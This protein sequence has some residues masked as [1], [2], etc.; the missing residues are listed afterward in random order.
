MFLKAKVLELEARKPIVVLNKK[1]SEELDVKPL[2]RLSLAYK[3]KKAVAIV[4]VTEKMVKPGYIGLYGL[5]KK[6]LKAKEDENIN[7]SPTP[8]PKSLIHIRQK[9]DGRM[10]KP[11]EIRQVI[12]DVVKDKLSEIEITAFIT[13]LHNHGM[14][15]EET[16]A[17]STSMARTGKILLLGKDRKK[18]FDKH[19]IGGVCGDKTSMLLVPIIAAAG[20]TI[21]KTSSRAITSPAGTADRFECLAPV[22]LDMDEIKKTV[23]KTNGCLVWGGGVELAPADDMFIHVEYPLSIDPMLLPSVMSKKI[24]VKA[25]H[26]VIDIPTGRGAKIKTIGEANELA[27][28]FIELGKRVGINVAC[29]STYGE[30]PLG[31][32]IG[33]A[34]EAREA[35]KILKTGKGPSD[36]IDKVTNLGSKLLTFNGDKNPEKKILNI[37]KTKKA[38]KKLKEIIEAQGGDPDIKKGDIPVGKCCVKVKSTSKGKVWWVSNPATIDVA[39]VAG[40]P[41]NKGAGIYIHK[42][43]GDTVKKGDV[44]F[45]VFADKKYKLNRALKHLEKTD[46][47]GVGEKFNMIMA[48][49]P[50]EEHGKRFVFER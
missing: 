31:H 26:V 19:S 12:K 15:M 24:A 40:A 5:V 1:D 33:P 32:G 45:E 10:L 20:L 11:A 14:S 38:Y 50:E 41:G 13:A 22:N 27:N 36:L 8:P 6:E 2:D 47:M 25:K 4:N 23:R 46:I 49:I 44:L 21:P 9:I 42:K 29:F 43:I 17:L 3:K 35:L 30:Q 7:V 18:V 34:L 37:I 28:K 16:A 48:R 39:R